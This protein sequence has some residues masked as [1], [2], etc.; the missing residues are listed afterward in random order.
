ME[1]NHTMVSRGHPGR[2]N[3]QVDLGQH[4][5]EHGRLR[6]REHGVRVQRSRRGDVRDLPHGDHGIHLQRE[7]TR[8]ALRGDGRV[9]GG[10]TFTTTGPTTTVHP[11]GGRRRVGGAMELPDLRRVRRGRRRPTIT[12][13]TTTSW[14][15]HYEDCE[16]L[17]DGSWEC[18]TW[19]NDPEIEEGNHTMELTVE[20]LEVG[21]NYS[22]SI[23]A[24][25]C[26]N[27]AGC[28][29]DYMTIEFNATAETMSE[30]FHLETDNYTCGVNIT[31]T[32]TRRWTGRNSHSGTTTSTSTAPASSRP[33][34]SP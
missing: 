9:T 4:L 32:C 29:Y 8:H 1:D 10:S 6:H 18:Q 34:R 12:T 25:I 21:T 3:S 23:S 31:S 5:R 24:N 26:E 33:P 30:T 16:E 22:V 19:W 11:D 14:T 2:A 7:H 28:E 17:S 27:M 13:G 20:D 15:N